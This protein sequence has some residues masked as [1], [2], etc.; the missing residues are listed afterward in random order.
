MKSVSL[1]FAIAIFLCNCESKGLADEKEL[2]Y[3]DNE[4]ERCFEEGTINLEKAKS[5]LLRA[6]ESKRYVLQGDQKAPIV[7]AVIMM[8]VIDQR[9]DESDRDTLGDW[10]IENETLLG[11]DV[12][13]LSSQSP[14][15]EKG[16][17]DKIGPVD[18]AIP[19]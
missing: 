5:V 3:W 17:S 15:S 16:G 14:H 19:P 1:F 2:R 4:L 13:Q 11:Y 9:L 10:T 7:S 6:S 8:L 12:K 18:S